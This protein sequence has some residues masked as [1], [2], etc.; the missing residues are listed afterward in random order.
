M[1]QERLHPSSSIT[2]RAQRALLLRVLS[3]LSARAPAAISEHR[4]A[5]RPLITP[6]LQGKDGGEDIALLSAALLCIPHVWTAAMGEREMAPP[7][8]P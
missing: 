1:P 5:L 2:S 6:I 8:R 3:S 4:A 7:A